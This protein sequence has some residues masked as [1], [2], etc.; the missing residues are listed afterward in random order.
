[1]CGDLVVDIAEG[2]GSCPSYVQAD[3]T[4]RIPLP[5]DSAVIFIPY[6]LEYVSDYDAAV[7]ELQ[8]VAPGRVHHL[9]VEPWTATAYFYQGARRVVSSSLPSP[10][11][12]P[13]AMNTSLP[14]GARR[15]GPTAG[16]RG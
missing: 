2:P 4:K 7:R 12:R 15:L 11:T 13:S 5:D 8:R 1:M 14:A 9:R 3:I 10:R 6:V 16:R